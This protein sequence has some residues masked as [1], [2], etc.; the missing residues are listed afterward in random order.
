MKSRGQELGMAQYSLQFKGQLK[1]GADKGKVTA[2]LLK[3]L[4]LKTN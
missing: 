2:S 3:T 4:K 1:Q